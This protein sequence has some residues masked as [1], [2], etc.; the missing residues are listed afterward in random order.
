MAT[1]QQQSEIALRIV[2]TIDAPR[3]KVFRA[4]TTPEEL[5]RW[6]A[7]GDLIVPVAEVDLRVGGRFRIDMEAPDGTVHRATGTYQ[8]VD[9]PKRLVYTFRWEESPSMPEMLITVEFVAQGQQTE[10]HF[11]HEGFPTDKARADHEEGWTS[12]LDKLSALF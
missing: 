3:E 9:T 5:K 12:C 7:P 1:S 11:T 8:E 6:S 2:R 4:W 10:V